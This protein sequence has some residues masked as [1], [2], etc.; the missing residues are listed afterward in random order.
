ML[1]PL[2]AALRAATVVLA[3]AGAAS[4]PLSAQLVGSEPT[5]SPFRDLETSQQLTLSAGW[6]DA[7][8]DAARVGPRP[9]AMFSLRH[10]IHLA[11]PAWLTSRYAM[12]RSERRLIDPGF[13]AAQRFVRDLP[14]THHLADVG[15]TMALTGRKSWRHVV[16]T[17]GTGIGLTSDF[18]GA[19]LGSYRFGTKFAFTLGPGV[20]VV[21]PSGY[22]LRL[23][24]TNHVYQFQYP[25]TYF[26]RASDSTSVLTDTRQR[27]SWR[28]NWGF[29]SGIS[30]PLFRRR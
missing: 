5:R 28:S 24:V 6:F 30:V 10:D 19:D 18:T 12:V 23:D 17:F 26:S 1:S 14:V 4:Q 21:L 8:R 22:S 20:R 25:S 13:P 7:T 27:S 16:P 15:L 9:A 3:L 11:G 2:P 29:T